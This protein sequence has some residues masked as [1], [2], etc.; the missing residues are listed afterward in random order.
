MPMPLA[1]TGEG[2]TGLIRSALG[3]LAEARETYDARKGT[4]TLR[5]EVRGRDNRTLY[6][7]SRS[8][9]NFDWFN[10]FVWSS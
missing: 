2:T 9:Y 8:A 5:L 7:F 1:R 10:H 4:N 3:R 6:I